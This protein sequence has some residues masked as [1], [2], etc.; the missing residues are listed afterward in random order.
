MLEREVKLAAPADFRLPDLSDTPGGVEARGADPVVMDATYFDTADLRLARSGASLRFRDVDGWTVKLPVSSNGPA[1]T[2][3]ELRVAGEPGAPPD[4]AV[5]LV[6]SLIRTEPLEPVARLQSVRRRV[7]LRDPVGAPLAEIALDDV[8]V[9]DGDA[10]TME[11]RELEIELADGAPDELIS[12]LVTRLRVAGAGTP[13]PT[14]K[15]VRALGPR[16]LAPPDVSLPGRLRPSSPVGDVVRASIAAAATRLIARDPGVRV[17]D[18]PEDV[19]QA[20]VATRRLRSDLRTFR[21]ILDPDWDAALRSELGWLGDELGAVRDLDVLHARLHE[22]AEDLPGED[23]A[24]AEK[25]LHLLVEARAQ[26]RAELLDAMRSPRYAALLDH[27]VDAARA[28]ALRPAANASSADVL[29]HLV[30]QQWKRLR[31]AVSSLEAEPSDASL[32]GVRICAKRG[33]YAA[34][35]AAIALGKP[36]RRFARA[37]G[38]CQDV[39]GEHQ[40][41]VVAEQW[42]REVSAEA[43]GREAFVAGELASREQ[44]AGAAA[45]ARFARQWKLARRRRLRAWL[46]QR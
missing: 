18:D 17:G 30:A 43:T 23:P 46:T 45:R 39:L 29:P 7:E 26:A 3:R 1:L 8:S 38:Q 41:A 36:A 28:P 22:R 19:H 11:F 42:L 27:L 40:D 37:M 15:I 10:T 24:V 4:R 9:L 35:A 44:A 33:R 31:R 14:P 16:A 6:R 13:D 20:R 32:H 5:D 25:L 12:S 2:R 21:D 34:E